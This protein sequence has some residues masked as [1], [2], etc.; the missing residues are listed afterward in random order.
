V[1]QEIR[2]RGKYRTRPA[3][4]AQKSKSSNSRLGT[5]TERPLIKGDKERAQAATKANRVVVGLNARGKRV[6]L[7]L[8]AYEATPPRV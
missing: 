5:K 7:R 3:V 8:S 4:K 1:S 6:K 2:L